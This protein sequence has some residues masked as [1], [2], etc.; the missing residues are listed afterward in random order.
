[1]FCFIAA[2]PREVEQQTLA[3]IIRLK[4]KNGKFKRLQDR[5]AGVFLGKILGK[6]PPHT[7][8]R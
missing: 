5:A 2:F 1:M 6:G 3:S 8:V 7:W 4:L